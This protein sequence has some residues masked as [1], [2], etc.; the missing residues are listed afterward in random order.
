MFYLK[1]PM[2]QHEKAADTQ[3]RGEQVLRELQ[4]DWVL[5]GWAFLSTDVA[6]ATIVEE[7][8]QDESSPTV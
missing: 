7:T 3:M 2:Q 8:P 6:A 5:P 4:K 1:I